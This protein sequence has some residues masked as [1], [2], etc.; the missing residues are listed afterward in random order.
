M[1][2]RTLVETYLLNSSQ[3][4]P[5]FETQRLK[6][7]FWEIR[8]LLDVY[9]QF[10]DLFNEPERL[11][12]EIGKLNIVAKKPSYNYTGICANEMC[13]NST[14]FISIGRGFKERCSSECVFKTKRENCLKI[15]GVE[16]PSQRAEIKEKTARTNIGKYGGIAPMCS[17]EVKEKTKAT[18]IERYGSENVFQNEDIKEKSRKTR[19]ERYGGEYTMNSPILSKRVMETKLAIGEDGLNSYY[20]MHMVR[21]NDIDENGLNGYE[22]TVHSIKNDTDKYGLNGYDRANIVKYNDIDENGLNSYDRIHLNR[23]NDIDENGLNSYDRIHLNRLNDIDENGLNGYDRI[24]LNRLSDIDENGLNSYDRAYLTARANPNC[25]WIPLEKMQEKEIYYYR[26]WR[27]TNKNNL[28]VLENIEHRGYKNN[29]T[30]YSLDHKYSIKQGFIDNVPPYIIGSIHNLEM[31]PH[32]DNIKKG[33]KCS[34][35]LDK[36]CELYEL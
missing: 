24:H 2:F 29:K 21:L 3:G 4:A 8:G 32:S 25:S 33:A 20:R 35:S 10:K 16:Y 17:E 9:D 11:S 26:V 7:R 27:Y 13:N 19:F 1:D 31:L 28:S 18:N 34:I 36:L 15:Y 22:R 14:E 12:K 30:P 5:R 23:L 6:R